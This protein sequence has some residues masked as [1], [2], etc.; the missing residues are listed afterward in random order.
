MANRGADR[1]KVKFAF[2]EGR[3]YSKGKGTNRV[4]TKEV[5][6]MVGE[7]QDPGTGKRDEPGRPTER[8]P[9]VSVV[10][11]VHNG[12][13]QLPLAIASVQRQSILPAEIIVVD[14]G[15]TEGQAAE[16]IR[17]GGRE[18]A[19]P[20]EVRVFRR[21]NGG[22][23]R[24]RNHGIGLARYPWLAFLDADDTWE[25]EKLACQWRAVEARPG[26]DLVS[27]DWVRPGEALP[28]GPIPPAT[29][30]PRALERIIWLNRFQTS[31][32]LVRRAAL[33]RAGLF[34]PELDGA[35]D[36]DAWI[37]VAAGGEVAHVAHPL[38][39][40]ADTPTGVSKNLPALYRHATSMLD[41]FARGEGGEEIGRLLTARLFVWHHLRFAAGFFR[42]GDGATA[43]VCLGAAWRPGRRL[44]CLGVCL[45]N[46]LPF[47]LARRL[48]RLTW[49]PGWTGASAPGGVG[50]KN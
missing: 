19:G 1:G 22:P 29:L 46:L 13:S 2:S 35:E 16:V 50:M 18:L 11:P 10:I 14:D 48:R 26:L 44:L 6:R 31:T 49:R 24:A 20:V 32:V 15:S 5:E 39:R 36:W 30:W 9:A 17:A 3:G 40:Y 33:E 28:A 25:A 7:T 42:L 37:R 34:R 38:V 41:G 47:L 45:W 12:L 4:Q 27:A 23:S 43:A 21:E 8:R